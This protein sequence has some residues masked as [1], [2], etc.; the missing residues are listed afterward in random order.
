MKAKKYIKSTTTMIAVKKYFNVR[1]IASIVASLML[2]YA[3]VA[4]YNYTKE[5]G[6]LLYNVADAQIT[7]TVPIVK[8]EIKTKTEVEETSSYSVSNGFED[9]ENKA[10]YTSTNQNTR[11]SST[12]MNNTQD[13]TNNISSNQ[14]NNINQTNGI[15]KDLSFLKGTSITMVEGDSFDPIT[16]LGILAHDKDGSNIT[17]RVC[18]DENTVDVNNVGSYYVKASVKL[19]DGSTLEKIF[20]VNVNPKKEITYQVDNFNMIEDTAPKMGIARIFFDSK[21]SE[22]NI[23]PLK[24]TVN[25]IEYKVNSYGKSAFGG[26]TRHYIDVN[27]G[28][29]SGEFKLNVE[30]VDF[31][32]G[33]SVFPNKQMKVYIIKSEP[34]VSNFSYTEDEEGNLVTNFDLKDIDNSL[35]NIKVS[36]YNEKGILV[37]EY[38]VAKKDKYNLDF[39]VEANGKYTLEVTGDVNIFNDL[40]RVNQ[41]RVLLSE[42]I[43]VSKIID[44]VETP[45]ENPEVVDASKLEANNIELSVGEE[46]DIDSLGIVALDKNGQNIIDQIKITQLDKADNEITD[47]VSIGDFVM[48]TSK[49]GEYI[50]KLT[51]DNTT[52]EKVISVKVLQMDSSNNIV[53]TRNI[54]RSVNSE[55]I[56]QKYNKNPRALTNFN[57]TISGNEGD[58]LRHNLT[59]NGMVTDSQ[60]TAAEGTIQV[61]V[62]TSMSF[63]V[64]KD[65]YFKAATNYSILNKSKFAVEVS[66]VAF[67]EEKSSEG[68]VVK[69]DNID[70]NDARNVVNLDLQG[71]FGTA[72]LC[73]NMDSEVK[74]SEIGPNASD[75]I[76]LN[77]IAGKFKDESIDKEGSSENFV[78]KFKIRKKEGI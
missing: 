16:S 12:P 28:D 73:N 59:I 35:S 74:I 54:T 75:L 47:R 2:L 26:A 29:I 10:T 1:V 11:P 22:K 62:P 42:E 64:N 52:L 58:P 69:K 53:N 20:T 19:N 72:R 46:F 77:G 30:K 56:Y 63:T 39:S 18:I 33:V 57:D 17:D 65:G 66:V 5:N 7:S 61:E 32:N 38:Q 13:I 43:Q 50:F 36:L 31:S 25:G 9:A 24:A 76:V 23:E 15:V 67:A 34:V 49:P 78:V 6:T 55:E 37:N 3:P 21:I 51:I 4:L 8:G 44:K 70:L 27:V 60:G 14:S 68:I 45:I 40:T 71:N 41:K 48:D